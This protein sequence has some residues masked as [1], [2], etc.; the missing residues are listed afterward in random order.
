[1]NRARFRGGVIRAEIGN[2]PRHT[3]AFATELLASGLTDTRP[4][5]VIETFFFM[6]RLTYV[7][8]TRITVITLLNPKVNR[9]F[10]I[11]SKRNFA[12]E[13]PYTH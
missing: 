8:P 13:L 10:A 3:N 2:H 6:Y 11:Y 4:A 1:M 7:L 12:V 5:P 9:K